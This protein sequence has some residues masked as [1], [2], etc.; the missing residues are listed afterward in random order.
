MRS[1]R[2]PAGRLVPLLPRCRGRHPLSRLGVLGVSSVEHQVPARH[3]RKLPV[4]IQATDSH[5]VCRLCLR[6]ARGS[7]GPRRTVDPI[8]ANRN[9]QNCSSLTCTRP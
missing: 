3:L 8:G 2:A 7:S 5:R 9:G 6:S 1:Q 4:A